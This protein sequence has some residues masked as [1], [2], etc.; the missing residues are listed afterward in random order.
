M[1]SAPRAALRAAAASRPGSKEGRIA[2]ISS[3]IGFATCQKAPPK[4]AASRGTARRIVID[5]PLHQRWRPGADELRGLAAG[6]LDRHCSGELD[7]R[8]DEGGIDPALEAAARV[9]DEAQFLPG[10]GDPLGIEIGA[11]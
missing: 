5:C 1:L 7:P 8:L 4:G 11:F 2:F 3:L 10:A 6:K 9:R